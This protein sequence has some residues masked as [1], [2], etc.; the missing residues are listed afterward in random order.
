M[1]KKLPLLTIIITIYFSFLPDYVYS[2]LSTGEKQTIWV[3]K[4]EENKK[5]KRII[6]NKYKKSEQDNLS[7]SRQFTFNVKKFCVFSNSG[8]DGF[9]WKYWYVN[10]F[11]V[12][13][14]AYITEK[15]GWLLR[16]NSEFSFIFRPKDFQNQIP[17]KIDAPGITVYRCSVK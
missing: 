12:V 7:I 2:A 4:I 6:V 10:K 16:A 14:G 17:Y 8:C 11:D 9:F 1:K 3:C 5:N 15:E 13:W